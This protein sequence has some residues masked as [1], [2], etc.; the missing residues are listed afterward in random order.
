MDFK[1]FDW[2]GLIKQ[3]A[4]AIASTFGGPL[5]GMGV[6]AL[7]TALLGKTDGQEKEIAQALSTATPDI[8]LKI[9]QADNE[10][11]G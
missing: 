10:F 1:E 3:V 7:S 5:A 4:P 11:A 8:I 6:S 9:K 2:K